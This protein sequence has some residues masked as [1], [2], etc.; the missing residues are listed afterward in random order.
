[1]SFPKSLFNSF[2]SPPR[3]EPDTDAD[4][5][6]GA[7]IVT[8]DVQWHREFEGQG[9]SESTTDTDLPLRSSIEL[10]KFNVVA[11]DPLVA[12]HR[13]I[14]AEEHTC[15]LSGGFDSDMEIVSPRGGLVAG[16]PKNVDPRIQLDW[17]T[18]KRRFG[19][20]VYQITTGTGR[21][22]FWGDEINVGEIEV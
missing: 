21:E 5:P 12:D 13:D 22:Q 1:M 18:Q 2:P 16:A 14:E 4:T 17:S 9:H 7:E 15:D 11:I 20:E 19:G 8:V 10:N 3:S 6:L